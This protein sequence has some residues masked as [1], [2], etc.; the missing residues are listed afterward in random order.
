MPAGLVPLHPGRSAQQAHNSTGRAI[1][2]SFQR[3]AAQRIR[4]RLVV[5]TDGT[6]G[7][8][9]GVE[10][11]RP[12]S[13]ESSASA[14]RFGQGEGIGKGQ[15]ALLAGGDISDGHPEQ[16]AKLDD[17]ATGNGRASRELDKLAVGMKVLHGK[18][19]EEVEESNAPENQGPGDQ[20]PVER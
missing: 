18:K 10:V 12:A 16:I 19:A 11:D 9:R 15:G 3:V 4:G 2:G 8:S 14:S 17:H 7:G 20:A 6:G 13:R 5:A 1:G